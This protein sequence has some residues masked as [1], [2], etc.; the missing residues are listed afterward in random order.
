MMSEKYK[1]KL[2]NT[3]KWFPEYIE[4]TFSNKNMYHHLDRHINMSNADV[5]ISGLPAKELKLKKILKKANLDYDYIL[6]DCPPMLIFDN[7]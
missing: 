5:I 3:M 2:E 1:K 6:I 4:K 7:A